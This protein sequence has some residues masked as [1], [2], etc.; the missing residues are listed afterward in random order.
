MPSQRATHESSGFIIATMPFEIGGRAA[1]DA[2][3]PLGQFEEGA[4]LAALRIKLVEALH[5]AAPETGP[6]A[7]HRVG[8][9]GHLAVGVVH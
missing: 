6:V 1:L 5:E 9:V 7:L 4:V 2:V 8:H 3:L